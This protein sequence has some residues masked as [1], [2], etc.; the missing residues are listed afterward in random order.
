MRLDRAVERTELDIDNGA[1]DL[2]DLSGGR[3]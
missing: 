3:C 2:G 1:N